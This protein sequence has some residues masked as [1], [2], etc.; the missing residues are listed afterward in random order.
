MYHEVPN[1]DIYRARP[2][3]LTNIFLPKHFFSLQYPLI[4]KEL[5]R[6]N[7]HVYMMNI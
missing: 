7:D 5:V 4:S 2:D 1:D 3:Q 6:H